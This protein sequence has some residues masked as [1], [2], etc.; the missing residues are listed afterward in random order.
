[1]SW[2]IPDPK[3]RGGLAALLI[4][5][6]PLVMGG[7]GD[8]NPFVPPPPAELSALAD[9]KSAPSATPSISLI[10]GPESSTQRDE[11][12]QAARLEAAKS[13]VYFT[14]LRQ[15]PTDSSKRQADLIRAALRSD[16]VIVEPVDDPAVGEAIREVRGKGQ[17]V[18]LA[19]RGVPIPGQEGPIP[20]VA[21]APFEESARRLVAAAFKE[22]K[23]SGLPA[24]GHVLILIKEG[25]GA[26]PLVGPI[27]AAA[28]AAGGRE[29]VIFRFKG[30]YTEGLK[31]IQERIKA[32]PKITILLT[33]D[34]EGLTG[35]VAA[36]E[37]LKETRSFSLAAV[38]SLDQS[39]AESFYTQ[40]AGLVNR[41]LGLFGRDAVQQALR[42]ARGE[43]VP[44]LVEI[45]L[46]FESL[47]GRPAARP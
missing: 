31:M 28:K 38:A 27:E 23:E 3:V 47:R 25:T 4:V 24:D 15:L 22:A 10:L 32:D 20:A 43:K 16:V 45:P 34:Q 46:S 11:W 21:F 39:L 19:G 30:D 33:V 14:V 6:A 18:L 41:N 12:V 35:A 9:P 36:I 1:M 40:C 44:D 5:V 26:E 42:L 2:S 37:A 17:K 8:G 29:V 13:R 7:C